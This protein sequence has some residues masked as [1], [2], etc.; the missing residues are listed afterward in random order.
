MSLEEMVFSENEGGN[1]RQ[2]AKLGV[3]VGYCPN[4]V[5]RGIWNKA[6]ATFPNTDG[7]VIGM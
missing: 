4:A 1:C 2:I 5:K 6:M 3:T 7:S